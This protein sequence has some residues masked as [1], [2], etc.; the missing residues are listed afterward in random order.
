MKLRSAL[1][2]RF[3]LVYLLIL[4]VGFTGYVYLLSTGY[5]TWQDRL[6]FAGLAFIGFYALGKAAEI[7][8]NN[9][10]TTQLEKETT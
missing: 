4:A 3:T 9:W 10:A 2:L 5:T 8:I 1:F 7:R 6:P